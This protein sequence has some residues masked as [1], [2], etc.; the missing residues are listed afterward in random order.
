MRSICKIHPLTYIVVLILI[1]LGM[2][3]F[4]ISFMLV[5]LIHELGHIAASLYFKWHIKEMKILPLGLLL[6][7]EG[8]LNKPLKEELIIASMGV[9]FQL[10][11]VALFHNP[12]IN[13]CSN[14]ILFFNL[15]PIYPLDGSK[16]IN[17]LLNYFFSFKLSYKLTLNLSFVTI[18]AII[19]LSLVFNTLI[20]LL[21]LIPLLI[22]LIDLIVYQNQVFLKFLLERYLNKFKFKKIKYIKK[23]TEMKRDYTHFFKI[24]GQIISEEYLLTHYFEKYYYK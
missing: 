10:L 5:L 6:K 13:K 24:N 15:L 18:F 3:R 8:C 12:L 16:I 1:F 17:V 23:I 2:F 21:S 11:F 22:N 19:T 4:Y 14:I 20:L 9:I 7:F